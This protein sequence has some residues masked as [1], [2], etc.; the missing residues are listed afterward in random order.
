VSDN[1]RMTDPVSELVG[2]S[3]N[4]RMTDPVSQLVGDSDN[5]RMTDH[6]Q[7]QDIFTIIN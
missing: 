1:I 2:D 5:I 6:F 7:Y 3:D 4:I